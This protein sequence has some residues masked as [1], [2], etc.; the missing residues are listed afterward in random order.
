M[1]FT[2]REER[3]YLCHACSASITVVGPDSQID[4]ALRRVDWK[5]EGGVVTCRDCDRTG[6][7]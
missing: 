5:R 3:G 6:S 4:K 1:A 7:M 2:E